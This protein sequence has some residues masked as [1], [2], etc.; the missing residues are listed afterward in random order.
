MSLHPVGSVW[1]DPDD[2]TLLVL[3]E[4]DENDKVTTLVL[5]NGVWQP[6][7][8]GSFYRLHKNSFARYYTRLA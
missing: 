6:K 7:T 4:P 3:D 2:F 5:D 1:E 8:L